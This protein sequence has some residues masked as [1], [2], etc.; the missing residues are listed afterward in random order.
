MIKMYIEL[1]D[2]IIEKIEKIT[3]HKYSRKGNFIFGDEIRFIIDDLLTEIDVLNEKYDDFK[4]D[5]DDNYKIISPHEQY[6][7]SNDDFI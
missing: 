6:G 3:Y 4:K 5:V 2:E 1:E 7:I